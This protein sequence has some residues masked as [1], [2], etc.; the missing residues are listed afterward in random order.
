MFGAD[1]L[2]VGIVVASE[3]PRDR[4]TLLVRIM[5]GG[6]LVAPAVHELVALPPEAIERAIAEPAL[7]DF[8]RMLGENSSQD[9]DEQEFIMAMHKTWEETRAEGRA[10]GRAEA[11]ANDVLTVLRVRG[12]TIPEAVRQQILAQQDLQRLEQWL[13]KAIVA[14]S[15]GDVIDSP[16]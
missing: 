3:L 4:T 16:N 11:R 10:E 13:E 2:R 6:P 14:T 12:I 15:I 1:V 9:A 7:L 5:A 8:R